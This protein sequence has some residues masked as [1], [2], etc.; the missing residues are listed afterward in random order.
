MDADVYDYL[1]MTGCVQIARDGERQPAQIMLLHESH[2]D[3]VVNHT[4]R[5]SINCTPND[6][7]ELVVG[8]LYTEG[9]IDAHDDL[10]SIEYDPRMCCFDVQVREPLPDA[11]S[12]MCPYEPAIWDPALI[13]KL[14]DGFAADSPLH[15]AS[16]GTHSC[17]LVLDGKVVRL[18]ED[19]SR[20]NATDKLIG[21]AVLHDI[22][23]HDA[24]VFSSGRMPRDMVAKV[25]RAR[26]GVLA[27]KAAPTDQGVRLA[28]EYGLVLIRYHE[29][30]LQVFNS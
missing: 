18:F 10:I 5:F 2:F 27:S 21:Y 9:I 19:I 8:H 23:L 28:R 11:D 15:R 25:V 20:H 1:Q 3:I 29:G 7:E 30:K 24:I 17:R 4:I 13:F 12:L 22:D 6:L 26:L 16:S 14:A